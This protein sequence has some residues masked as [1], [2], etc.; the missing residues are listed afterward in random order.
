MM[1]T[2][3]AP[4][5]A[6]RP[7]DESPFWLKF[8][9]RFVGSVGSLVAL[10]LGAWLCVTLS[11]KCLLAGII[12]MLVAVLVALIE[13]P[14]FCVFLDFAQA[15]SNYFE[16]KAYWHR[17]L[18]YVVL[19]VM[20]I[21]ICPGITTFFGSGLI[22]ITGSLYGILSLGRKAPP[23]EMKYRAS[24]SANLIANSDATLR[25]AEAGEVKVT[26]Q[27]GV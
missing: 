5:Q 10:G 26:T 23:E 24:S 15:P 20:P 7:L 25:N 27:S 1:Q 14:C 9:V 3:E 13:A 16:R 17:G 11:P 22:F 6:Q 21:A 19:S 8:L 2:S 18:L 12:Q 4:K